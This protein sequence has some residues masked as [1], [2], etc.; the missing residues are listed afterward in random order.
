[1]AAV[2]DTSTG[3]LIE[4]IVERRP[5]TIID[6]GA[7]YGYYALGFAKRCPATNVIAYE[8]DPTHRNIIRKYS[9]LNRIASQVEVRGECTVASLAADLS[10]RPGS[11]VFMD[12]EGAEDALL[13][14]D[15][16]P[17]LRHAEIV[18]ELHEMFVPGI[19]TRLLNQFAETHRGRLIRQTRSE[20]TGALDTASTVG[21]LIYS[22]WPRM[23]TKTAPTT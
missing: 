15:Q 17:G 2:S 13:C 14:P 9:R 18:V 6:V 22:Y 23:T 5:R 21:K 16:A 11:L 8:L 10:Q 4:D 12:V 20:I 1:V 3:A 7:C 19:T